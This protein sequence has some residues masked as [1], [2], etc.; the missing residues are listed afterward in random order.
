MPRRKQ[1]GELGKVT[2][3]LE[4]GSVIGRTTIRLGSGDTRRISAA[5]ATEELA[6]AAVERKAH[7]AWGQVFAQV[8]PDS[9]IASLATSWLV[10]QQR[11]VGDD[12][13][14]QSFETYEGVVRNEIQP[15]LWDLRV[16]D[17][18]VAFAD[19]FLRQLAVDRSRSAAS[20]VESRI[21][22]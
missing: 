17:I 16:K 7:Q 3:Y 4:G 8:E 11:R 19:N 2:F 5:G 9:T 21:V 1:P 15:H 13:R 12:L 22:V 14:A 18:T 20:R 10:D 6:L